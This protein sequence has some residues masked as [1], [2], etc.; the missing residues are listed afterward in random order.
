[1]VQSLNTVPKVIPAR[2][3]LPGFIPLGDGR[4]G[5]TAFVVQFTLNCFVCEL[6]Y[7]PMLEDGYR[8][9]FIVDNRMC[10]VDLI[11]TVGRDE[12][13]TL[14]EQCIRERQGFTFN[15]I[16]VNIRPIEREVS[17]NEGAALARRL[18]CGFNETSAKMAQ[19]AERVFTKLNLVCALRTREIPRTTDSEKE[20]VLHLCVIL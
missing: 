17:K 20:E 1:M 9:Q 12:Y 3:V 2:T 16:T 19:N 11:D 18:G 14:Q 8:K 4:V 13:A 6:T 7:D 5:R 15:R 10:F